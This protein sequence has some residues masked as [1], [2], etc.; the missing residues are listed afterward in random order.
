MADG[1]HGVG[2]VLY[3]DEA[4]ELKVPFGRDSNSEEG[5][6]WLDALRSVLIVFSEEPLFYLLISTQFLPNIHD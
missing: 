6:T 1:T 4:H 3:I 2:I 5:R